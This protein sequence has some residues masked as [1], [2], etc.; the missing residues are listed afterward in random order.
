[1]TNLATQMFALAIVIL[2]ML[3]VGGAYL[4]SVT[5]RTVWTLRRERNAEPKLIRHA[6]VMVWFAALI[7]LAGLAL[8]IFAGRE[9]WRLA[10]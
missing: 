8:V 1:M 4:A 3:M 10:A 6:V 7:G 2:G 5:W 9:M